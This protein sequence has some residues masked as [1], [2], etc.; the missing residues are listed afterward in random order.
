MMFSQTVE[1]VLAITFREAVSRRHT[2]V[3]VEHLLYVLA[4]DP[5]GEKILQACGADVPTLSQALAGFL[6]RSMEKFPS[7]VEGEP[8]QTAAF[9]RVLQTAVL[10]VQSAG[11]D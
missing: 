1:R 5:D 7:A 11:R 2:H 3:T 9:R 4:H 6:D 8:E 10:H